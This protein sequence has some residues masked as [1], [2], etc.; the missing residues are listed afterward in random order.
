MEPFTVGLVIGP[1]EGAFPGQSHASADERAT[2][3]GRDRRKSGA[4]MEQ[5]S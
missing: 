2:R 4:P 5:G 1:N 3:E